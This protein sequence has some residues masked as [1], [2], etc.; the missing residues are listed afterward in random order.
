M[1][2]PID[3][4]AAAAVCASPCT[5]KSLFGSVLEAVH[6]SQRDYT[7]GSIGSAIFFW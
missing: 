5:K 2:E 1:S 3:A 4:A 6:G 7:E